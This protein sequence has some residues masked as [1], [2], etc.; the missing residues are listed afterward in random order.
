MYRPSAAPYGPASCPSIKTAQ[1]ASLPPGVCGSVG[2]RR[3]TRASTALT[4]S[5][6]KNLQTLGS[7]GCGGLAAPGAQGILPVTVSA[8]TLELKAASAAPATRTWRRDCPRG[9]NSLLMQRLPV[10]SFRST[11]DDLNKIRHQCL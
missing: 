11:E 4:S 5:G 8:R 10:E 1:P 2:I 7:T 6:V 9:L 3:S